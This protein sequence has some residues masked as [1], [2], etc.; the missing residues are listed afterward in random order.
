MTYENQAAIPSNL[1]EMERYK[2]R[3]IGET[4]SLIRWPCFHD[5][6]AICL[7]TGEV[8]KSR[9]EFVNDMDKLNDFAQPTD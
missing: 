6:S 8:Y 5:P 4:S 2:V 3:G 9:A 7:V 1:A